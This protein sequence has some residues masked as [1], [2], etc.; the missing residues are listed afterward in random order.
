MFN[1]TLFIQIFNFLLVYVFLARFFFKPVLNIIQS[2]VQNEHILNTS[3]LNFHATIKECHTKKQQII[4]HHRA[5]L[6]KYIDF[7][8]N[9]GLKPRAQDYGLPEKE[10]ALGQ[11]NDLIISQ[12]AEI[13]ANKLIAME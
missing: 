11:K 9:I 13:L 10:L 3:I 12:A 1:I 8:A 4:K 6:R 7:C 5:E 2:S